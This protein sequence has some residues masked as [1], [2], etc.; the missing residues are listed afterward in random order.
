MA[1][2]DE[3]DDDAVPPPPNPRPMYKAATLS[4]FTNLNSTSSSTKAQLPQSHSMGG[5][6][7]SQFTTPTRIKSSD[8]SPLQGSLKSPPIP[9]LKLGNTSSSPSPSP[10]ITVDDSSSS[11]R[12]ISPPL[13]G[14]NLQVNHPP[15]FTE[16]ARSGSTPNPPPTHPPPI[17]PLRANLMNFPKTNNASGST[18]STSSS[19]NDSV[20]STTGS[21]TP[22]VRTSV[23]QSP[24]SSAPP[25]GGSRPQHPGLVAIVSPPSSLPSVSSG[26]PRSNPTTPTPKTGIFRNP[27]PRVGVPPPPPPE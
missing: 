7:G 4:A 2:D 5:G 16:R 25:F 24:I 8:A 13:K 21:N 1:D 14:N 6:I 15:P 18:S 19:S 20:T 17:K 26:A 9:P 11:R 23:T 22:V 12:P 27:F 3:E 10:S